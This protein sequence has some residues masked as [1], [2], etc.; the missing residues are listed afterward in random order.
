MSNAG[1]PPNKERELAQLMGDKTY[2]G[3]ACKKCGATLR[4]TKNGN[5]VVCVKRVQQDGRD[6]LRSRE[7]WD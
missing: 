1:R 2:E 5:C 4:Y 7:P 6:A 3:L